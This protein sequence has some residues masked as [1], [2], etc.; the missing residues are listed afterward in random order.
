MLQE[1][2]GNKMSIIRPV[3]N[4]FAVAV[5]AVVVV[6]DEALACACCRCCMLEKNKEGKK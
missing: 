1:R 2:C 6:I 4:A 3:S 5:A